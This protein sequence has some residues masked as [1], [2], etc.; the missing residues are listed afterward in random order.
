MGFVY[1]AGLLTIQLIAPSHKQALVDL[2]FTKHPMNLIFLIL[3]IRRVLIV[4]YFVLLEMLD[5]NVPGGK[6]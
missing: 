3:I 6:N 1:F 5:Y 2:R 4:L